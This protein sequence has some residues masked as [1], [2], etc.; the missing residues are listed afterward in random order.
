M[1]SNQHDDELTRIVL[2]L[3]KDD[4]KM[5]VEGL[6]TIHPIHEAIIA[7]LRQQLTDAEIATYFAKCD[8]KEGL[9]SV[10]LV[11]ALLEEYKKTPSYNNNLKQ[12]LLS[13]TSVN[14]ITK[15]VALQISEN[16]RLQDGKVIQRVGSSDDKYLM[17]ALKML[18]PKD[19]YVK[20]SD[21]DKLKVKAENMRRN[22][23]VSVIAAIGFTLLAGWTCYS[24]GKT[25]TYSEKVKQES[26]LSSPTSYTLQYK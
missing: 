23:I 26:T 24:L 14:E 16:R 9:K 4:P 21:I 6:N 17:K 15:M 25:S 2:K 10:L 18:S 8:G 1:M 22:K 11:D 7:L 19:V 5:N 12:L 3:T 20:G 13:G